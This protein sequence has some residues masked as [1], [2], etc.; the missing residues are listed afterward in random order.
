MWFQKIQTL[1]VGIQGE[2]VS[3]IVVFYFPRNNHYYQLLIFPNNLWK[4]KWINMNRDIE[5]IS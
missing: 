4:Y 2:F 5:S 3:H 1:Q